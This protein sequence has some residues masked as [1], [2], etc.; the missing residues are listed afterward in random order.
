M[1]QYIKATYLLILT[2]ALTAASCKKFVE[3]P[4][5]PNQLITTS[6]FTDDNTATAALT[7]I[8]SRMME[9]LGGCV[10]QMSMNLGLA[11]DELINY[12]NDEYQR[13]FYE[14]ALSIDNNRIEG[15]WGSGYDG[16][17]SFI[18]FA[19]AAI[20]E[21]NAST[22]VSPPVKNMLVGEAKF[23]RAFSLFYLVNLFGN[24][25]LPLTTDYVANAT[26]PRIASAQVYEQI[27]TDLKEAQS[28]L[29][30][31]HAFSGGER[32]RPTT[33]AATALL[34]R[35]YLY[36]KDWA[37]A[38]EQ[39]TTVINNTGLFQLNSNLNEVFLANSTETIWQLQPVSPGYNTWDGLNF[40][41][42]SNPDNVSLDPDFVIDI[43]ST[44]QRKTNWI[45]AL[46]N[47]NTQYYYAN[48]YKKKN[49]YD[50]TEYYMV[51]RLAEQYLI[52]SEARAQ[53]NNVNGA[54]D[55][56][57]MIR[58]RA[59]LDET[60]ANEQTTML[61]AIAGERRI[62]L[63]CE[64]GH[65]WLDLKRT[66]QADAVL[67]TQKPNWKTTAILFPLPKNEILNDPN[68]T[69]NPGY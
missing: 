69:Q 54:K 25:P 49:G 1:N 12:S 37:A 60:S 20:E 59:G 38:E 14:N 43:D 29:P 24:V 50:V 52:R 3:V 40:V 56:L 18:Y 6:V 5:P 16:F 27:V 17:Y 28:L 44:D 15:I 10:G 65:R 51:F 13:Q 48:K 67:G 41:L 42:E 64:F 35:V 63:F 46:D 36:S 58:S 8:Y 34:A 62:E 4:E 45:G 57:N 47:N 26:L 55:D 32:I 61:T 22:Q 2:T 19:N 53:Q 66:E 39:A 33:W 9:S 11:A 21:L 30:S 68:L 23:V 7:G 31:N